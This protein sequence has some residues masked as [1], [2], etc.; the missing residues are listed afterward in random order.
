MPGTGVKVQKLSKEGFGF[1]SV[2]VFALPDA[3]VASLYVC[4]L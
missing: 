1:G 3:V 2:V 4:A